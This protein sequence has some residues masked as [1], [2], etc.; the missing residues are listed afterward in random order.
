MPHP[1]A[2][3]NHLL[4]PP[5][6]P[7]RCFPPITGRRGRMIISNELSIGANRGHWF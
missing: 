7:G 4:V 6:S 5:C 2:S 3:H 1:K